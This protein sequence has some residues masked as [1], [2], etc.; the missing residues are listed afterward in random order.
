MV[1]S[2][3]RCGTVSIYRLLQGS[4]VLPYHAYWCSV[5]TS[6]HWEM[7][8]RLIAGEPSGGEPI[9]ANWMSVRAAEW[10]GA[11]AQ[12][13]NMV[14]LNHTDTIFAPIFAALHP[15]SK[16]VWLRRSKD[17]VRRSFIDKD[18]W[19]GELGNQLRPLLYSFEPFQWR[20]TSHSKTEAIDW[21]L[22]FT[23][24]FCQA[25]TDVLGERLIVVEAEDL[26]RQD[27]TEIA[28]LLD[29]IGADIDLDKAVKH[30]AV[31]I[32]AKLHK[33][34]CPAS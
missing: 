22:D 4:N 8:L 2:T 6:D 25:M 3:G 12:N 28:R 13:R 17:A 26:F 11:A 30:F 15:L 20:R 7:M 9:Y 14:G 34:V 18:Q 27:R 1:L 16:F 21:Y 5:P 10:I 33:L 19:Q 31:P 32:N 23:E 24:D 29:F